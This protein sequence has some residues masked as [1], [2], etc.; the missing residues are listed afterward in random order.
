MKLTIAWL[1]ALALVVSIIPAPAARAQGDAEQRTTAYFDSVKSNPLLL[2]A[3]LRAMPKGGDLH[4]HPSGSEYAELLI[5]YAAE[6]GVCLLRETMSL[7]PPPCDAAA[8]KPPMSDALRQ[9]PLYSQIVDAWSMRGQLPGSQVS[10]HD[11]FFATFD[12]FGLTSSRRIGDIIA[13]I[14]SRAAAEGLTYLELMFGVDRGAA[15]DLGGR[16]GWADDLGALHARY[17][18]GGLSDVVARTRAGLDAIEARVYEVLACDST[19]PDPGC[20]VDTR[21]L[22]TGTRVIPPE[23]VFAQLAAGFVLVQ[24]DPRVV[25][26][27]LV[28]PEDAYPARRDYQLH[29]RMF[30]F[31]HQRAPDVPIALHAGELAPGL[32]PPEDLRFHIREA[33]QVAHARRIGHG[34]DVFYEDDPLGLIGEMAARNVLVEIALSSNAQILNV[35]GSRHPMQLYRSMGVPVALVTD[36]M[37][38]SRSNMTEQYQQAVEQ[39]GLSY[40]ELKLIAR[41][42]LEHAFLPGPSLWADIASAIPAPACAV[43]TS[44]ECKLWL[45]GSE[46]ARVQARLERQIGEFEARYNV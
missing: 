21:Y 11:Q 7:T 35:Q 44:T 29:M 3:F 17:E 31:L 25:G 28:A 8:G 1:A 4:N 12:R 10:G 41:T 42:S 33:V 5:E 39:H 23:R 13:S 30:D 15:S 32:V 43:M 9:P 20:G 18:A 22:Q 16:I 24:A 26:V 45:Q 14:R 46:R 37:G 38:V 34:V 40:A 19:N 6:D 27:N 36:D 2:Y